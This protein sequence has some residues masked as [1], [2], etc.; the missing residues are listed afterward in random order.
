MGAGMAKNLVTKGY[1]LVVMGHRKREAVERLKA[2]GAREAATPRELAA[3]C[4]IVHLCVTGS[5]EVEA[6]VRG[7]NGL[8][9][10]AK[11]GADERET[12]VVVRRLRD[13]GKHGKDLDHCCLRRVDREPLFAP[14]T[15]SRPPLPVTEARAST[16]FPG[17]ST[18]YRTGG[19]ERGLRPYCS[20]S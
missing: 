19:V 1:P 13:R 2:L 20:A 7:E 8:L 3:L 14:R 5:P 16:G 11:P 12:G 6:S 10:G 18:R 17:R 15:P 4:D 9:A